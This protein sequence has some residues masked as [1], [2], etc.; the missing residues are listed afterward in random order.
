MFGVRSM[1]S[2]SGLRS[3]SRSAMNMRGMIGKWNDMWNSSPS[4][5]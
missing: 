1:M 5:K 3:S 4:P 2:M